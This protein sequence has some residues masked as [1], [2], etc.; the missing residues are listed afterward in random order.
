MARM[1]ANA[2]PNYQGQP[3]RY[4]S[5]GCTCFL[6]PGGR[7]RKVHKLRKRSAR[8]AEKRE[9]RRMEF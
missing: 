1:L 9:L 5:R 2:K 4:A 3:C 6:Y 7:D 8:L